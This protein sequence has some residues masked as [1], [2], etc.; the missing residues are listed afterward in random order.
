MY[1][2]AW[3]LSTLFLPGMDVI[4]LRQLDLLSASDTDRALFDLAFP[5]FA[6]RAEGRNVLTVV[7]PLAK[8]G[9]ESESYDLTES[10]FALLHEISKP[11][12]FSGGND[13]DRGRYYSVVGSRES[14]SDDGTLIAEI[15]EYWNLDAIFHTGYVRLY[16]QGMANDRR[17]LAEVG[18]RANGDPS[19]LICVFWPL[20]KRHVTEAARIRGRGRPATVVMGLRVKTKEIPLAGVLDLR[21]LEGQSELLEL[22]RSSGFLRAQT[23]NLDAHDAF[24]RSL[25]LLM[26]EQR[27]GTIFHQY[28]G[29]NL[30]RSGVRGLVYPSARCDAGVEL[31]DGRLRQWIG[32][33]FIDFLGL[34]CPEST[35]FEA[36]SGTLESYWRDPRFSDV[37][38]IQASDAGPYKG[39]FSV[40]GVEHDRWAMF[41]TAIQEAQKLA[42][43]T[44]EGDGDPRVFS[45]EESNAMTASLRERVVGKWSVLR[46]ET[47]SSH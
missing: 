27:G 38:R 5:E 44:L 20:H 39:T 26:A 12:R 24:F 41:S 31:V 47:N 22:I 30:R 7:P 36:A 21:Q 3:H 43:D 15:E 29:L 37:A 9:G 4:K 40:V 19:T 45:I 46:R 1:D 23:F 28:L 17:R 18:I 13:L 32:W 10:D 8:E 16:D 34:V 33:C 11:R 2:G 35:M 14:T 25:P 42:D 6:R